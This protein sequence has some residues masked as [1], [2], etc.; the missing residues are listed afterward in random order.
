MSK[1]DYPNLNA[2]E[3]ELL[4]RY[5]RTPDVCQDAQDELRHRA[6]YVPPGVERIRQAVANPAAYPTWKLDCLRSDANFLGMH[7]EEEYLRRL[8]AERE[9]ARDAGHP[10]TA[11]F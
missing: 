1:P 6:A 3:L 9:S 7:A 11:A 5:G 10:F 4:A 2:K 8:V